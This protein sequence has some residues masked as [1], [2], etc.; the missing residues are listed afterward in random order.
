MFWTL[1]AFH[2][3][4]H[5]DM[6]DHPIADVVFAQISQIHHLI[7]AAMRNSILHTG[8]LAYRHIGTHT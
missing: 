1:L 4:R 8:A 6:E 2:E 3:K 5:A 7:E